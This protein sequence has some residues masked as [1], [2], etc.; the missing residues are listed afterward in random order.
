MCIRDR[1]LI[2]PLGLLVLKLAAAQLGTWVDAGNDIY[3][4][5]NVSVKQ[6][7]NPSVVRTLSEAVED[8]GLA[9]ER[10]LLE[11]TESVFVADKD[12]VADRLQKLREKGFRITIDDF[13]TG[14][15]SLQYLQ[16]FDF[17]VLKIDKS[18]VDRIG[19][20]DD[21]GMVQA[22][23]DLANRM[24]AVTVAEGIEA[25]QQATALRSLRCELGQGYYFAR[26]MSAEK[27]AHALASEPLP[28]RSPNE[29]EVD[30]ITPIA[31]SA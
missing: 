20:A 17:D 18:F 22:V 30:V 2:E 12:L 6:L 26:P 24:G 25:A 13:G 28:L 21:T 7:Q 3:V 19:T 27:T 16:Q 11:V 29:S 14:Y 15:S 8:A 4:S 23:L 1:G 31:K 5:V 9:F 10:V